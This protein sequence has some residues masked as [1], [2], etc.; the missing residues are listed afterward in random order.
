QS[1]LRD[2]KDAISRAK[3]RRGGDQQRSVAERMRQQRIQEWE[4]RAGG[5]RGNPQAWRQTGRNGQSGQNG[6]HGEEPS[7]RWGTEHDP[8][9][10]DDP[11]RLAQSK[12]TD[13]QLNG[14]QGPGLSRRETI[15][16]SA[17]KGFAQTSYRKVYTEYRKVIEEVMNQEKV[18]QGYKYYVKRYFQR[19][20]PHSM[21]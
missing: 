15:L 19:I 5:M 20:K 12:F 18:P 2:L 7:E 14:K 13:D 6:Q 21:D 1:Q 17:Q 11:T 8:N 4:Q 16:T 10:M 9:L 3:P